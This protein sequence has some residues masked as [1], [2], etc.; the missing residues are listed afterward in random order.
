[1]QSRETQITMVKWTNA[2]GQTERANEQS[3][4]YRPPTWRRWRNVK[5]TYSLWNKAFQS[6]STRTGE[7]RTGAEGFAPLLSN[8]PARAKW[9][10]EPN[11]VP[12]FSSFSSSNYYNN[13]N[14]ILSFSTDNGDGS[15]SVIFQFAENVTEIVNEFTWSW[16]LV[17]HS[18][19]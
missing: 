17:E 14:I 12:I 4:V 13:S 16:F 19:V 9:N 3:F 7:S 8:F 1:M 5:T 6:K 18:Q 10:V 11:L 15:E 2:G